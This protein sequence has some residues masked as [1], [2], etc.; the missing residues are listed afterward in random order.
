MHIASW[1]E[2]STSSARWQGEKTFDELLGHKY[3]E[4]MSRKSQH[5]LKDE[6]LKPTS[7][8]AQ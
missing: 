8:V 4:R 5:S 3:Y 1:R 6:V 2:S 7:D